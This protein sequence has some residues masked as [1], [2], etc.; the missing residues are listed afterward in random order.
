MSRIKLHTYEELTLRVSQLNSLK[1]KQEIELKNNVK[2]LYESFRLKNIIK[3][4]VKDLAN[5]SEFKEDGFKVATNFIV[6]KIFNKNNS[7]NGTITKFIIEKVVAP[8]IKNNKEKIISFI[9]ELFAKR[10]SKE[11]SQ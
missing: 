7:T 2:E 3:G 8:L 11:E 1:Y 9:T 10:K 5:D 4:T 6:G